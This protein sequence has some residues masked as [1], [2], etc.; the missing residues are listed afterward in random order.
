VFV[1]QK[2]LRGKVKMGNYKYCL[3]NTD[4]VSVITYKNLSSNDLRFFLK[5]G[6]EPIRGRVLKLTDGYFIYDEEIDDYD[7]VSR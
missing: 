4:Y 7:L 6:Y 1:N 5:A 3:L 2:L